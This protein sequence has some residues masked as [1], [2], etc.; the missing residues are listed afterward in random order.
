MRQTLMK[1]L[2]LVVVDLIAMYLVAYPVYAFQISSSSTGYVRVAT[3]SAIGAYQT[4]Q[5][6]AFTS[7]VASAVAGPTAAS[8]TVRLVTG[9]VGWGL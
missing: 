9:P 7:A 6:A 8:M 2:Y 3:A 4:A 1:Y 5:R